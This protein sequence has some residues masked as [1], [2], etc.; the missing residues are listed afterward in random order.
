MK[1][2]S[3]PVALGKLPED[4]IERIESLD[5]PS[6]LKELLVK[7]ITVILR[8]INVPPDEID[9]LVGRIDERGVSEMLTL[10]NYDVQA[11]RREARAEAENRLKRAILSLLGKGH[12]VTDIADM[13]GMSEQDV[14][15]M[16]PKP[17]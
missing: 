3:N 7:V 10:E 13:M 8:K 1:A 5:V 12:T 14:T 15:D 11:T 6:H 9:V 17:A 16:L 4:Y 2:I